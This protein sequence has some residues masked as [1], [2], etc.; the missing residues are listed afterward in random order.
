[1]DEEH[2]DR[3]RSA[4]GQRAAVTFDEGPRDCRQQTAPIH[5]AERRGRSAM[6]EA[7]ECSETVV[8]D[9]VATIATQSG[10][11]ANAACVVLHGRR[12]WQPIVD[13]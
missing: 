7:N 5:R 2:G 10:D 1:M 9:V 8:H 6:R 4:C 3:P 13:K 12:L 11:E